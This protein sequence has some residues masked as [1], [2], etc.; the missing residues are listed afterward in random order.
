[1][2]ILVKL[3]NEKYATSGT[4]VAHNPEVTALFSRPDGTRDPLLRI[5]AGDPLDFPVGDR[6]A[7]Y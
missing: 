1:M 4:V 2:T 3:D 7:L 6:V 5:W